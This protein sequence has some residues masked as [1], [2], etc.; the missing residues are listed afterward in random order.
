M[1]DIRLLKIPISKS[2]LF[3]A[4]ICIINLI[5][6]W[7]SLKHIP[8]GD[9]IFYLSQ[10]ANQK[11]WSS[12]AIENMDLN[13][14]ANLSSGDTWLFRP[15][16]YALLG[17]ERFLFGYSFYLW[18]LVGIGIHLLFLWSLWKLLASIKESWMALLFTAVFSVLP[19]NMDLVIWQHINGY[20][21]ALIF[22]FL[23]ARNCL[24]FLRVLLS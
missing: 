17:T 4:L 13:R 20:L 19:V 8:R 23:S 7:P 9:Q 12:L 18:Q 3:F 22:M 24:L 14:G 21:V 2:H 16:L 1:A 11:D 5:V 15:F 6:Y 10:V